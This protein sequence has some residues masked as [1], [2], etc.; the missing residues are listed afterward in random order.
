MS[1]TAILVDNLSKLYRLGGTSA[2]QYGSLRDVLSKTFSSPLRYLHRKS[3]ST[4]K[5]DSLDLSLWALKDVGFDIKRGEV[6]GII[7]RNGAG[8]STLLKILSRITEPTKGYA[9]I[10]GRV[11]SLLE[12][13]TGFHPELT[14]RENI[15]LNGA[16]LGMKRLEIAR[17]FDEIVAFAEIEKFIDTPVKR[18]SSGMYTRLA[19][20]VAAHMEPEILLVDEVLAV[21]DAAFQKK[22]LGK[23]GDVAQQGRTILFVSHNM[24]SMSRLCRQG[25]WLNQGKLEK[26]GPINDVIDCY[27]ESALQSAAEVTYPVDEKKTFQVTKLSI[28]DH[29][30]NSSTQLDRIYPFTVEIEYL[31]K[32]RIVGAHVGFA[33]DKADGTLVC[34]TADNDRA[35]EEAI[36][37]QPGLYRARVE[38]PGDLLIPGTYQ[39]RVA[40]AKYGGSI[41]DSCEPLV[42]H[43][44]DNGTFASVEGGGQHRAGIL[45]LLLPWKTEKLSKEELTSQVTV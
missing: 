40:L 20:S 43:L 36:D 7:G 5:E 39:I 10:N 11:G 12:V 22:C 41:Y 35:I 16:I 31:V 28:L 34:S 13:G 6:I 30:G 25:I 14:G 33:L 23:M 26:Q 38:F 24:G 29:W 44:F 1:E 17:K 8:K 3:R 42:F 4:N 21:G 15:Y 27:I 19:F 2:F 37:R 32:E 9:R 45:A 18:Y